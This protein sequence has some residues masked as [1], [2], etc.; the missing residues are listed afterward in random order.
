MSGTR[1]K[2]ED[3]EAIQDCREAVGATRKPSGLD[4]KREPNAPEFGEAERLELR[5]HRD[6]ESRGIPGAEAAR[7][8]KPIV[9]RLLREGPDGYEDIVAGVQMVHQ[10]RSGLASELAEAYREQR[11]LARLVDG[12]TSELGKLDETLEVLSTYVRRMGKSEDGK[13]TLH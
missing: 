9:A 4:E 12:F 8:A 13:Q 3:A 11:Q 7:L 10:A 2:R 5:V 1:A 6:L